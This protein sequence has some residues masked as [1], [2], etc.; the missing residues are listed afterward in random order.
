MRYLRILVCNLDFEDAPDPFSTNYNADF[1]P[2]I[3]KT[4]Q[5]AAGV[6]A[7]SLSPS[8]EIIGLLLRQDI[9]TPYMYFRP[10]RDG[11]SEVR[12]RHDKHVYKTYGMPYVILI[13]R[14]RDIV[15]HDVVM[16]LG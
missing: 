8:V 13:F 16:Q 10:V 3:N 12:A 4:L 11:R 1:P 9:L 14:L 7:R 6:L 15:P 2:F 5:D